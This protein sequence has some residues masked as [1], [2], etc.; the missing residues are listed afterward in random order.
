MPIKVLRRHSLAIVIT[1][2]PGSWQD[3]NGVEISPKNV[4]FIL[5]SHERTINSDSDP[6]R[7]QELGVSLNDCVKLLC[8]I[9]YQ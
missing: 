3:T 1:L 8:C 4:P 5:Y 7:G 2:S 6:R 9:Q